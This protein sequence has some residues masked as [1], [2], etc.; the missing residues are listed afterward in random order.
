MWALLEKPQEL[1]SCKGISF[2]YTLLGTTSRIPIEKKGKSSLFICSS[3]KQNALPL[4]HPN[5]IIRLVNHLS[6]REAIRQSYVTNVGLV[7][8]ALNAV[9]ISQHLV[10]IVS[11]SNGRK[12]MSYLYQNT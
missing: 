2:V 12:R 8:L 10:P 5:V 6:K 3:N 7:H 11:Q 1:Q 9:T 4:G